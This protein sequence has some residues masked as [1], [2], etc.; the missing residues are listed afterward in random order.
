MKFLII[1]GLPLSL[2]CLGIDTRQASIPVGAITT[3]NTLPIGIAIAAVLL[4]ILR[5]LRM[6]R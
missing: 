6:R 1:P 3:I 2:I 5:L 4:L